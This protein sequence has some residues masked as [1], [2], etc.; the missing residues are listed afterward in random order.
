MDFNQECSAKLVAKTDACTNCYSKICD[1]CQIREDFLFQERSTRSH[2]SELFVD[3]IYTCNKCDQTW[4]DLLS[5]C[6]TCSRLVCRSFKD[7]HDDCDKHYGLMES[8]IRKRRN[9]VETEKEIEQFALNLDKKRNDLREICEK[10]R[11]SSFLAT[12]KSSVGS[13]VSKW[14]DT[15]NSYARD[16]EILKSQMS[17]FDHNIIRQNESF[18]DLKDK[19]QHI[20]SKITF[21]VEFL[22]ELSEWEKAFLKLTNIH[23]RFDLSALKN[24]PVINVVCR[25]EQLDQYIIHDILGIQKDPCKGGICDSSELQDTPLCSG[26][27][28]GIPAGLHTGSLMD[29]AHVETVQKSKTLPHFNKKYDPYQLHL[30]ETEIKS[31]DEC[32]RKLK[33]DRE[34]LKKHLYLLKNSRNSAEKKMKEITNQFEEEVQRKDQ[35]HKEE[36]EAVTNHKNQLED[37]LREVKAKMEHQ[38]IA[39]QKEVE[40]LKARQGKHIHDMA[41]QIEFLKLEAQTMDD[42]HQKA[43]NDAINENQKAEERI[44]QYIELH[45]ISK[46]HIE[47]MKDRV[48]LLK[49]GSQNTTKETEEENQRI[50]AK[51]KRVK[52]MFNEWT[53]SSSSLNNMMA[54]ELNLDDVFIE[55]GSKQQQ[56]RNQTDTQ[57]FD[58]Q[59]ASDTLG[60]QFIGASMTAREK[61]CLNNEESTKF[62][63]D[64][65][66]GNNTAKHITSVSYTAEHIHIIQNSQVSLADSGYD[67]QSL[68]GEMDREQITQ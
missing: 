39:Q 52:H 38:L 23:T 5:Y 35:L 54:Y 20:R 15:I 34:T 26:L 53:K 64:E 28:V 61:M 65:T 41:S 13:I 1:T 21:P 3:E 7:K 51:L 29:S 46:L 55:S 59:Q 44:K 17:S 56:C 67:A 30:L 49:R 42:A 48:D 16:S 68:I 45:E 36:L 19:M 27:S 14:E 4:M 18:Q 10:Y 58:A 9:L 24:T 40:D 63:G 33:L 32:I 25:P 11:N 62:V 66:S 50:K 47:G 2:R 12:L 31:K 8:D 22:Q 37:D 6:V 60:A 57:I 43:I